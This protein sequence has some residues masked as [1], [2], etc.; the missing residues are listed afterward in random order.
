MIFICFGIMVCIVYTSTDK[1]N[2]RKRELGF[3]EKKIPD[4]C[5]VCYERFLVSLKFPCGHEFCV[6]CVQSIIDVCDNNNCPKCRAPPP[7]FLNEWLTMI[8]LYTIRLT[9]KI[10]IEKLQHA[11][12]L[13]CS[14]ANLKTVIKC[15]KMGVDV[16]TKG[17]FE[18]FPLHLASQEDVVKH[19]VENGANINQTSDCGVTPLFVSS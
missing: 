13:I 4:E 11:F 14:I 9:P 6:S 1:G 2:K 15:I 19:L 7:H 5:M 12:P 18:K 8:N 10:S 16:N 3:K 17:F